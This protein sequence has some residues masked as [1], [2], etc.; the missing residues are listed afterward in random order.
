[1]ICLHCHKEKD[2]ITWKHWVGE[3]CKEISLSDP[4]PHLFCPRC[5]P[6]EKE[7]CTVCG[8]HWPVSLVIK[9]TCK[10]CREHPPQ[11]PKSKR[12]MSNARFSKLYKEV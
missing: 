9:R 7:R 4:N 6:G 11:K 3:M 5:Y 1:M 12:H 10:H 2:L 8:L